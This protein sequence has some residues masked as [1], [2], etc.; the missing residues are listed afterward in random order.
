IY[1]DLVK[2]TVVYL[3]KAA[4]HFAISSVFEVAQNRPKFCY[5]LESRDNRRTESDSAKLV[6]GHGRIVSQITRESKPL[7]YGVIH[8]GNEV[9][10]A[11]VSDLQDEGQYM[12][13]AAETLSSF[14]HADFP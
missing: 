6:L 9:L 5:E 7:M 11:G 12:R 3:Y 1:N 4:A 10:H 14:S 13:M 8:L 2:P